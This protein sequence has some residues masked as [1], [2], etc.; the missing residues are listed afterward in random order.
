MKTAE[1]EERLRLLERPDQ[2]AVLDKLSDIAAK[3]KSRLEFF[4]YYKEVPVLSRAEVLYAFG[5]TITCKTAETQLLAI[6][7]SGYT[8]IRSPQL[9]HNLY[10]DAEVNVDSAEV[11]LSNFCY[12]DVLASNRETMRVNIGG[13]F[14]VIVEAGADSF[15]AKLKNLS[16]GGALL[17]F[18]D[19][20]LLGKFSYFY[21]NF[22]FNLKNRNVPL[23]L[24]VMARFLRFEDEGPPARG[25][26]LFEH[27]R[28]SEDQ[29]GM[30]IAQRQSEI[31]G[32][33][34]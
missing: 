25:I 27:D 10:A 20:E 6:K 15:D 21:I 34:K 29:I 28:R 1:F 4:N 32:E 31:L 12:V 13:L 23:E 24:R 8:I 18:A 7:N 30:F 11:V 3:P 5:E 17:E 14:K 9:V 2:E 26:F 19:K 33:L 16:L 22:A